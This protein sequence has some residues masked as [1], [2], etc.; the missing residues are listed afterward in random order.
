[1]MS[2]FFPCCF[3]VPSLSFQSFIGSWCIYVFEFI[4]EMCWASWMC[5]FMTFTKFGKY[6]AIIS[7]NIL[8][9]S[10]SLSFL[11]SHVYVGT[12]D[13][14]SQGPLGSVHFFILFF[15]LLFRFNNFIVLSSIQWFLLLSAQ[16][17]VE[18]LKSFPF[19]LLYF[20]I[21]NL[22]LVPFYN[23]YLFIYIL[24]I[25]FYW[26]PLVV[27]PWFPFALWAYLRKFVLKSLSIKSNIWASSQDIYIKF[28][29][30]NGP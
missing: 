14:G 13:C 25:F 16:Y 26:F 9:D 23:F 28:F 21:Q 17:A 15:F 22:Y 24:L 20:R 3:Q 11:D 6:L 29:P 30:M 18:L 5:R 27:C 7:S 8:P 19:Q 2:H 1:M 12:F 4:L 10:L